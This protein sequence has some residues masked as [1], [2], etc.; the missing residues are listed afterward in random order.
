L[1]TSLPHPELGALLPH[2]CLQIGNG[3]GAQFLVDGLAR[4]TDDRRRGFRRPPARR[5]ISAA[6]ADR[7]AANSEVVSQTPKE[8]SGFLHI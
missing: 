8:V 6:F 3:R 4:P 5:K 7:V 2:S 1:A